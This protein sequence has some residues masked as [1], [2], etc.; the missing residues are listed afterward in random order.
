[1]PKKGQTLPFRVEFQYPGQKKATAAYLTYDKAET[2]AGLIGQ[3]GGNATIIQIISEG[4]MQ[5][6]AKFGPDVIHLY[7]WYNLTSPRMGFYCRCGN[8]AY[9]D[10]EVREHMSHAGQ[11]PDCWGTGA[12]AE[13]ATQ[14]KGG[15][16]VP[17][18]GNLINCPACQG[19]G[20]DDDVDYHDIDRTTYYT[21]LDM[22]QLKTAR[23]P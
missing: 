5:Q 14:S 18:A 8:H 10:T 9:K 17:M 3:R 2:E 22:L 19:S 13:R 16:Q 1:M 20:K 7:D 12:V 11:C 23:T 15:Q 4:G 6:R 21:R